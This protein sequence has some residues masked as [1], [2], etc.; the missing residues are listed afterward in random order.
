M[1]TSKKNLND[2][3]GQETIWNKFKK[4]NIK[5]NSFQINRALIELYLKVFIQVGKYLFKI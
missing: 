1:K 3:Q 5:A 2:V 4:Q